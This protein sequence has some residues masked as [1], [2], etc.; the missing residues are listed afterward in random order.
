MTS[1]LLIAL[2]YPGFQQPDSVAEKPTREKVDLPGFEQ[3]DLY[4]LSRLSNKRLVNV[5]RGEWAF[6]AI[7]IREGLDRAYRREAIA[8]L[9]KL[10]KTDKLTQIFD[11]IARAQ[12]NKDGK[13][14]ALSDLIGFP[15]SQTFISLTLAHKAVKAFFGGKVN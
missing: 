11:G 6:V 10:R 2:L 4:V 13:T 9:A 12:E 14:G 3:G 1:I 8:E 5:E 15:F 7:L